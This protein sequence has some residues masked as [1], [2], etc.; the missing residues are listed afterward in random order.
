MCAFQNTSSLVNEKFLKACRSG[1]IYEVERLLSCH[2]IDVNV[3]GRDH[4]TP[5]YNAICARS[6]PVV[7]F[8]IDHNAD[9]SKKS[10]VFF[11]LDCSALNFESCDEPPVVTATRAGT[12]EILRCLLQ[13][14]CRARDRPEIPTTHKSPPRVDGASALHF[15]C[16]APDYEKV[17]LLLG[18]NGDP[19]A[20]DRRSERP[21]HLAVRCKSEACDVQREIIDLLCKCGANVHTLNKKLYSPFY[22]AAL[23]G[24][25][26]KVELLLHYGA[27]VNSGAGRDCKYG[28]AL[29]IAAYK[30]RLDLAAL[31]IRSGAKINQVNSAGYTPLQLN[32]LTHNKSEIAPLL[33]YHGARLDVRDRNGLTLLASC[34][35]RLRLDCESLAVLMVQAGYNL[36]RELWLVPQE[37][38][39]DFTDEQNGEATV[40]VPEI[41]IPEGRVRRLCDWLRIKQQA[42]KSLSELCRIVIRRHL[43]RCVGGRTIVAGIKTL[44]LPIALRHFL[45]LKDRSGRNIEDAILYFLQSLE[46]NR[47]EV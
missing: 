37:L 36:N 34:I 13:N 30:D 35:T 8:L 23:Y 46:R 39:S 12:S 28:S 25:E 7:Q 41:A 3:L 9:V 20:T 17:R 10:F 26:A 1:K 2:T 15:A 22:L 5:L 21:L 19:N 38:Q 42:T 40:S 16:E 4:K 45:L 11:R 6:L 47:I 31:L 32:I 29:H 24:C 18:Y 33:V 27:R 14:G 44:P 43:S